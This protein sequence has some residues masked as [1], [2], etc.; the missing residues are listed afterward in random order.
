ML[1]KKDIL[2]IPFPLKLFVLLIKKIISHTRTK[3]FKQYLFY[4]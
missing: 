2:L 1:H 3:I 4:W